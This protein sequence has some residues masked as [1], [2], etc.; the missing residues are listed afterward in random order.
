MLEFEVIQHLEGLNKNAKRPELANSQLLGA[1]WP[2]NIGSWL[3]MTCGHCDGGFLEQVAN[4]RPRSRKGTLGWPMHARRQHGSP[5]WSRSDFQ[6][7]PSAWSYDTHLTIRNSGTIV[8]ISK[9]PSL[10]GSLESVEFGG[11]TSQE[12]HLHWR[13]C[14]AAASI[15]RFIQSSTARFLCSV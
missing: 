1:K 2:H 14:L 10:D 4:E 7:N 3:V 6:L 15:F 8:R 13:Q 11:Q 5:D 12:H 9:T